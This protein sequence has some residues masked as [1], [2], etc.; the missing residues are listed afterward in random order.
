MYQT[1]IESLN[2]CTQKLHMV[3]HAV[4]FVGIQLYEH[5]MSHIKEPESDC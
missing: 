1:W 2:I 5:S 4:F 3:S